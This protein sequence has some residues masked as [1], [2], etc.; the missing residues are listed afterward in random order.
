MKSGFDPETYDWESEYY[1]VSLRNLRTREFAQHTF[2]RRPALVA[3][4]AVTGY[5]GCV[6]YRGQPFDKDTYDLVPDRWDH[7]T[8]TV[9]RF[10][11]EPGHSYWEDA[12]SVWLLC[13]QCHAYVMGQEVPPKEG[14]A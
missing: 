8:C 3:R 7:D 14:P 4:S 10:R 5:S 9:C 13:D 12:D 1:Q 6:D 2:T 11:I